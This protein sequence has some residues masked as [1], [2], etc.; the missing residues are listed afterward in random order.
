[1]TDGRCTSGRCTGATTTRGGPGPGPAGVRPVPPRPRGE[2]RLASVRLSVDGGRYFG[3]LRDGATSGH[4]PVPRDDP[5]VARPRGADGR[6]SRGQ[7]G[8]R[9]PRRRRR[10]G[11][12]RGGAGRDRGPRLPA[13]RAVPGHRTAVPVVRLR[14]RRRP[15]SGHAPV[16]VAAR[17]A[18]DR[19]PGPDGHRPGQDALRRAG[20]AD[21]AEISAV[22]DRAVRGRTGLRA[23]QLRPGHVRAAD[24][25][26][27]PVLLPRRRRVRLLRLVR[28][29][30]DHR[31]LRRSPAR[32]RPPGRCGR[33]S[34]R[35]AR[36]RRPSTPS[37]ARPTRSAG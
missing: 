36:S 35:T 25:R 7:G 8:A 30:R 20:P 10:P 29:P 6:G 1:M 23:G 22:I 27:G 34:P 17:A 21:A 9:G 32:R 12:D 13:V 4:R 14:D 15:V 24:R 37:W 26:R 28:P 5:V 2:Q 18:A 16:P 19:T 11:A 33:C 31:V 3:A